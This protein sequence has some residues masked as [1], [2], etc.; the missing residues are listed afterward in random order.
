[1]IKKVLIGI[2]LVIGIVLINNSI[3]QSDEQ[4]IESCMQNGYSRMHCERSKW[5]KKR[6]KEKRTKKPP[7][8]SSL[9]QMNDF[10]L[11]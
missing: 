9:V 8:K 1:M 2:V 5:W 3:E 7:S 11:A 10:I 4:F 6:Q